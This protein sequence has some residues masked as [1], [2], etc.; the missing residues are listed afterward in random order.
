MRSCHGLAALAGL[1][2]IPPWALAT[3]TGAATERWIGASETGVPRL[4]VLERRAAPACANPPVLLIHA[5]GVPAAAGFDVP[6][7]SLMVHLAEKGRTSWALD[8]PGFGLSERPAAMSQAPDAARPLLRAAEVVGALDRA[9]AALRELCPRQ[10]VDVVGWSWGGV[11]AGLWASREPTALRRLVL[12]DTMYGFELP[13]MAALFADP[14]DAARVDPHLPAYGVAD[15]SAVLGQWRSM[16][17]RSR[18][19]GDRIVA[20]EVMERVASTFLAADPHPPRDGTVRRP[21]GPL[22]DLFE[23][24]HARPV[25]DGSGIEAPTLVIRGEYDSFADPGLI[26]RLPNSCGRREVIVGD[27]THYLL[28]E[29]ARTE[30]YAALDDFLSDPAM[31]CGARSGG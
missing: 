29:R 28:Y 24:W 4:H 17:A 12:L 26:D 30:L 2:L 19:P 20:S 22:V 9:V 18:L 3:P 23:I 15:S 27:A 21:N 25:Y 11:V 6:G 10:P 8:L 5:Y 1:C 14:H 7:V 16:L 31:P 13:S